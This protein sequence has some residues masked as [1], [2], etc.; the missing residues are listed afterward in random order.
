[1]QRLARAGIRLFALTD[2]VRGIVTHLRA[3]HK[4][5]EMFE[6]VTCSAEVG[7]LKPDARIYRSLLEQH[8]LKPDETL[9]FDD[10]V[11]NVQG[12]QAVGMHGRLFND[13][14]QAERELAELGVALPKTDS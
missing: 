1:M 9:F 13:A 14:A 2:N 5:W 10:V 12:A 11:H 7:V 8:G 3:E 4:F 6:G